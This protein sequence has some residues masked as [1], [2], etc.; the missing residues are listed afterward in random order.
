[1]IMNA[2]ERKQAPERH[3]RI[4]ELYKKGLTTEIIAI[5]M[6]LSRKY[7]TQIVTKGKKK[8]KVNA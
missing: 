2:G 7:V 3:A 4:M 6:G 5:R 8:D 1:M